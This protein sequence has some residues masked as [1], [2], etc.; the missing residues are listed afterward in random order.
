MWMSAGF[1]VS[2][3]WGVYFT[4]A[5]KANP[6]PSIVNVLAFVTQPV[7]GAVAVL[8][9]DLPIG[10]RPLIVANVATY[11]LIGLIVRT[12]WQRYGSLHISK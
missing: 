2:A 10:V 4:Y 3:S 11:A 1:L 5:N 12:I 7:V 9:P 6:V 8:Y